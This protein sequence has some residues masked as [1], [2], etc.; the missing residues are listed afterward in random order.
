MN[1]L[2]FTGAEPGGQ[3]MITTEVE[4]F[5]GY[6]KGVHGPVLMEDLQKQQ[7]RLTGRQ[8]GTIS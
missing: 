7:N 6:P 8:Y 4:N 5:P 1:P 2:L 3:L